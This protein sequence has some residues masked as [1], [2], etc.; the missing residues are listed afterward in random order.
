MAFITAETRSDIIALVVTML[1]RAPDDALLNELVTAS[2][3]GMSLSEIADHIAAKDEF[4]DANPASQTAEEYATAALARVLDGT[5]VSAATR[6][7]AI[8]LATSYLN[9]GMS[10]AGLAIEINN[11]LSQPSVLLDANFGDVAQTFV[12]KNTVAEYYVLDADLGDLT[13]AE[14]TA[15]LASVTAEADS[16]T[17]ATDAADATAAAEDVVAG[18]TFTLTNSTDTNSAITINAPRVYTPGGNDRVNSLQDEDSLTGLGDSATLTAVLGEPNDAAGAVITPELNTIPT[19]NVTFA[20]SNTA[21]TLNMQDSV[22]TETVNVSRISGGQIATVDDMLATTTALSVSNTNAQGVAHLLYQDSQLDGTQE[23][24]VTLDDADL[25]TLIVGS[26]AATPANQIET[27]NIVASGA[28]SSVSALDT[29]RDATALTSQAVNIDAAV[30]LTIGDFVDDAEIGTIT[31]TGAGDVTLGTIADNTV[32]GTGSR[33]TSTV[34]ASTLTGGLTVNYTPLDGSSTSSVT[35]GSGDDVISNRDGTATTWANNILADIA[36]GAGN[37][38]IHV[39]GDLQQPAEVDSD[40]GDTSVDGGAGDDTIIVAGDVSENAAVTGGEGADTI[41]IGGTIDALTGTDTTDAQGSVD[42]GA[43]DDTINITHYEVGA[44]A[45]ENSGAAGIT[46]V[47]GG[48]EGGDGDD[49]LNYHSNETATTVATS[50]AANAARISGVETINLVSKQS[51]VAAGTTALS[52]A[53]KTVTTND[54]DATTADFT[55]DLGESDATTINMSNEAV[56]TSATSTASVTTYL[57]GDDATYTLT[58]V[59]SDHALTLSAD[60][61]V[62]A[63]GRG[64]VLSAAVYAAAVAADAAADATLNLTLAATASQTT[65]ANA[66][67][68]DALTVTLNGTGDFAINDDGTGATTSNDIDSL[69]LV[70]NGT[71]ARTVALGA[72]DFTTALTLSGDQSGALAVT[73]VEAT[74]VNASAV[75]ANTTITLAALATDDDKVITMG[76][77]DDS[78]DA[79]SVTIDRDD[80]I[81]FGDGTDS[82]T[83]AALASAGD[84]TNSNDEYFENIT[85]LETLNLDS[86]ADVVLDDDA[87]AAGI[88]TVDVDGG[89]STISVQSDF[90]NALTLTMGTGDTTALD[91][92]ANVNIDLTVNEQLAG[93]DTTI[94]LTDAGTGVVN[95]T[96]KVDDIASNVVAADTG[97]DIIIA[98]TAGSVDSITLQDSTALT[99][100]NTSPT[101]AITVTAAAAWAG[102][103]ETIIFD[104]TDIDDDDLDADGDG[105]LTSN[106][107]I[108]DTQT[109]TFTAAASTAGDYAVDYRGSGLV[110]TFTG[111]AQADTV[112][113]GAGADV[114]NSSAGADTITGGAG[115]DNFSYATIANSSGGT[116]DTISDFTTGSDTITFTFTTANTVIDLGN[117]AS[118]RASLADSLSTLDGNAGDAFYATN[119]SVAVDVDGDGNISDGIDFVVDTGGAV[120]AGDLRYNITV[121]GAA[122]VT[123]S[124]AVDQFTFT[125]GTASTFNVEI[126]AVDEITTFTTNEDAISIS[127]ADIEALSSVT[128]LV[129]LD[130][131]SL[132]AQNAVVSTDVG[133]GDLAT[134]TGDDIIE[135][136]GN[137]ATAALLETAI[138]AGG[139]DVFIVNGAV[140]AG[141]AMLIKWDDGTDSYLG[142]LAFGSAVADNGSIVSGD[143][144]ITTI[145]ELTGV[146]DNTTLSTAGDFVLVA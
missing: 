107:D 126:G 127:I 63:Q 116:V 6:A 110:D 139:A 105:A 74:T 120:A 35:G 133:G 104:L 121:T 86:G 24:T 68:N 64:A 144:T 113:L 142:V 146:A 79:T 122:D 101:G 27:Y 41:N 114:Y 92:D 40:D 12:N 94:T 62:V 76:T 136:D 138:E 72:D 66:A 145:L 39:D 3:S 65:A 52:N 69:T 70:V 33:A 91:N 14:L 135:I 80:Q 137:Y 10:K 47:A 125:A 18:Q 1:D 83:V 23:V 140:D 28:L 128:D 89:A 97:N 81:D 82:L 26:T 95:I 77:G 88:V 19:V 57:A 56:V 16:V 109:V 71:A 130:V 119:G 87:Q 9:S 73:S 85:S 50:S 25:A 29:Q 5:G 21:M 108:N 32:S 55:F 31:V 98:A 11:Y 20:A 2:T 118:N 123:G 143:A 67:R 84:I 46:G 30:D 13:T 111:S 100:A 54:L 75:T 43:G 36:A 53:G 141:D 117:F 124:A 48:I 96:A 132:G 37:D 4:T 58:N 59:S 61:T 102:A 115:A 8:E 103:G 51:Y 106:T 34:D 22:G 45:Y 99:V 38:T 15:A 90:S 17:A 129:D 131:A 93:A 60:E 42:A 134:G 112:T 49:V 7:D 44:N 78:V